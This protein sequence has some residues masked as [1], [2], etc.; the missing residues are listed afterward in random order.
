MQRPR[1][2]NHPQKETLLHEQNKQDTESNEPAEAIFE[3]SNSE[4]Y[5]GWPYP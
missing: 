2:H 3:Y 1:Q 5:S 4:S